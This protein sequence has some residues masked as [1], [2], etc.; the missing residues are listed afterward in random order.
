MLPLLMLSLNLSAKARI[1][2]KVY[3]F[4]FAASFNDST[5]Y[6]TDIQEIEN[7]GVEER[8]DFLWGRE[9]Y[10]NQLKEY[11]TNNKF[12]RT[13]TVVLVFAQNR[14]DID[15]KYL[16]MKA[17][18]TKGHAFDV[19]YLTVGEFQ[20]KPVEIPAELLREQL[21]TTDKKKNGESAK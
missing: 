10:S 16:K 1:V 3:G 18:Y 21:K 20:F 5:V 12:E 9:H 13:R 8:T 14:K 15:K 4:G 2:N 11:L 6:F 17:K 19:K 7:V